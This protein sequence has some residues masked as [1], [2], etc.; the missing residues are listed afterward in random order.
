M[1]E[2]DQLATGMYGPLLVMEPGEE[3]DAH[4]D[5]VFVVG[6]SVEYW[7]TSNGHRRP[8]TLQLRAGSEYRL[9]F[10]NVHRGVSVNISLLGPARPEQWRSIAKDGAALPPA[11]RVER[12]AQLRFGAGETYDYLWRPASPG[13]RTLLI[14]A[15]FDTWVGESVLRQTLRVE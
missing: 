11:L 6:S 15:P 8:A 5:L 9:R 4:H 10:I 2:T 12:E 7:V 14:H 13:D 3:Y 1:D